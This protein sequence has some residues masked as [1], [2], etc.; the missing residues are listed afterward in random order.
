[1]RHF[2]LGSVVLI[3]LLGCSVMSFGGER[4]SSART[5]SVRANVSIEHSEFN[6]RGY[7]CRYDRGYDYEP[8]ERLSRLDQIHQERALRLEELRAERESHYCPPVS[9]C[10]DRC[11][12]VPVRTSGVRIQIEICVERFAPIHYRAPEPIRE[13]GCRVY[14][15]HGCQCDR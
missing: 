13:R 12:P 6:S 11:E 4:T 9:A 10:V 3:V 1:M 5:S 15:D 7:D 14:E 8:C 2:T